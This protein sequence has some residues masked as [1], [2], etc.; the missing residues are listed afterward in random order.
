MGPVLPVP[1]IRVRAR[2]E[3]HLTLSLEEKINHQLHEP[4]HVPRPAERVI[5][6]EQCSIMLAH[7]WGSNSTQNTVPQLA[8][9]N[10]TKV[11]RSNR[12]RAV[13]VL[14]ASSRPPFLF[15]LPNSYLT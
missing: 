8:Q 9:P 11:K 2:R 10:L 5:R 7:R 3:T 14:T 15:Q 1:E 12:Y 4:L 13:V 6:K